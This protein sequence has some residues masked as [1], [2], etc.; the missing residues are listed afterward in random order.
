MLIDESSSGGCVRAPDFSLMLGKCNS[1]PVVCR[2]LE[3]G[4]HCLEE[5]TADII[6]L[7]L[8]PL[9]S[10]G[11][12]T[13][14]TIRSQNPA[15][16]IIVLGETDFGDEVIELGAQEFLLWE[17][18]NPRTLRRA[19]SRA[20]TRQKLKAEEIERLQMYEERED[21]MATLT[22]DLKNPIIGSNIILDLLVQEK[23]GNLSKQQLEILTAIKTSNHT[24]LEMLSNFLDVYRNEKSMHDLSRS[25]IDISEMLAKSFEESRTTCARTRDSNQ[26]RSNRRQSPYKRGCLLA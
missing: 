18:T 13:L 20:Y 23:I 19:V 1:E 6:L 10:H 5:Q 3:A 2:S 14:V 4:L 8:D 12:D 22:H 16:P 11:L 24:L 17:E 9:E 25:N 26:C 21:F 7:D 15:I